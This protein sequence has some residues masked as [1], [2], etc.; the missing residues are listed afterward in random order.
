MPRVTELQ[1]NGQ[2]LRIDDAEGERS[3]LSVLR[4][5]LDLT[6]CKYGCG[7]G[8][9][10]PAPFWWTASNALVPRPVGGI[11]SRKV[12]PSKVS[13]RTGVCNPLQERF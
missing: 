12:T 2:R 11:G 5:D 4:D 10:G 13:N 9:C 8:E 1:V 6:G 7:E 3:L